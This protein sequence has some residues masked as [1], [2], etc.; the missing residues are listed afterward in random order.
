M[1]MR[2]LKG[3]VAVVTG[4]ESGIGCAMAD[5][6][7]AEGMAVVLAD[8]EEVALARAAEERFRCS[9]EGESIPLLPSFDS[10]ENE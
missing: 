2:G 9:L 5:A 4:A 1:A 3:T 7:V 10:M 8:A 6:F